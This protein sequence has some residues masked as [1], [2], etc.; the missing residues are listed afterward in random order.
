M[1]NSYSVPQRAETFLPWR[2]TFL[3]QRENEDKVSSK[4]CEEL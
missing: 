3:K 2:I 4:P 1:E